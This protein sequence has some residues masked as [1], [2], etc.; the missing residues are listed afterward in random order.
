MEQRIKRDHKLANLVTE[1]EAMSETGTLTYLDEKTYNQL[2]TYYEDEFLI[3]K[4]L[5]VVELAMS[6]Y[7]YRVEFYISKAKLL[8][9]DQQFQKALDII[10]DAKN[11]SPFENELVILRSRCIGTMGHQSEALEDLKE[12]K[13]YASKNDLCDIYTCESYI[14]ESMKD[15]KKMFKVLKSALAIDPLNLEALERM[16]I[17]VELSKKYD[18]SILFHNELLEKN[19]YN[20]L[21]WYN[22][23]HAYSC[24]GEYE[25]A[26][27]AMEYSF[28]INQN[29]DIA[30]LEC[31]DI[32]C[33]ISDFKKALS[34]YEEANA[35]FGPDSELLVQI[36]DCHLKLENL[37]SAKANLFSALRLDPYND[38]IY[39]LL[40]ECYLK[41]KSLHSA[42]SS[43][44]K[45][46]NIEDGREEYYEGIGKAYVQLGNN[47]EAAK[48]FD[49]ATQ[50]APEQEFLWYQYTSILVKLDRID[51]ALEALDEAE[52]YA[53]GPELLYCRAVC[54]SLSGKK[55]EA[56]LIL[57]EAL[58][59]N[60]EMH[61]KLFELDPSLQF[62]KDILSIIHYYEG[63]SKM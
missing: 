16:W 11:I 29:F 1:F 63:E 48:Y 6:Q 7:K 28:L 43:Y 56:L 17:S 31:A 58:I 60:F 55:K 39:F 25:K 62:D 47:N 54:L 38:E 19:P 23:G 36:S 18:D 33:Q 27:T 22:L 24:V 46:I 45:A 37:L 10:D 42:I 44:K 14:Y 15:F 2:I 35:N 8:I 26:I 30:Y 50:I 32:C 49:T 51:E 12:I 34:I 52:E 57:D 41:E 4:A 21:A 40:G 13:L 59:D 53:V 5:E 20:F 9:R 61:D 3:D